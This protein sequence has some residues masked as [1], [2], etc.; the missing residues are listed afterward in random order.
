MTIQ[1]MNQ[2]VC[3]AEIRSKNLRF[4]ILL[5]SSSRFQ[6]HFSWIIYIH[7]YIYTDG[8]FTHNGAALQLRK[9]VVEMCT[10]W[11]VFLC[12]TDAFCSSC[13]SRP[14]SHITVCSTQ[15]RPGGSESPCQPPSRRI[16]HTTP[17]F[18]PLSHSPP[19]PCHRN[20][21]ICHSG[22]S[23]DR[24]DPGCSNGHP[25]SLHPT[26]PRPPLLP[27]IL[28]PISPRYPTHANHQKRRI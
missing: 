2:V 16:P 19:L 8:I 28:M 4:S 22:R 25:L 13:T 6:A 20:H 7:H 21:S 1:G 15:T 26:P 14:L 10:W 3:N 9:R 24:P 12:T 17:T 27:P 5:P 18:H 23:M 11:V